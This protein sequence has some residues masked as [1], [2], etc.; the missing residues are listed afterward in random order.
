MVVIFLPSTALMGSEHERIA[1]PS[2]CTVHAPH[3][4]MPQPYF[5]PVRPT[6][7]RRTQSSGVSGSTCTS[8]TLPL[9]FSFAMGNLLGICSGPHRRVLDLSPQHLANIRLRQFLPE[10]HD[11]R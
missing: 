9:M 11:L 8:R 7:S 2:T 3:C 4:A 5:V 1:L 10:F 6:C